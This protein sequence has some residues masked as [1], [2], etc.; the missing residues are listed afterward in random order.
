MHLLAL[1]A[2]CAS[3]PDADTHDTDPAVPTDCTV[4][5]GSGSVAIVWR[6]DVTVLVPAA[7]PA[8]GDEQAIGLAGP[9]ALGRYYLSEPTGV[10]KRSDDGG[11]TWNAVGT[12][13]DGRPE[14]TSDTGWADTGSGPD[15]V[16]YDLFTAPASSRVYA[17]APGSLL[18]SADGVD[19]EELSAISLRAPAKLAIDPTNPDRLRGYD[20]AGLVTSEDAGRTWATSAVPDSEAWYNIAIDAADIDRVALSHRGLWVAT[21][22]VTWAERPHE[23]QAG[24]AWDNG[25]LYA[26]NHGD[27]DDADHHLRR[28]DDLG[29][30]LVDL[31]IETDPAYSMDVLVADGGLAVSAGY[32]YAQGEEVSGLVQLTT[33][34]GS[35]V[36]L[37]PGFDGVRGVAVGSDRVIVAFSGPSVDTPD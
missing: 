29:V 7:G 22:G 12:L 16:Y 10:V 17:Y 15:Y 6:A 37:A 4:V 28:S 35:T 20:A 21:D 36:H 14:G 32:R 34:A 30:T 23:L 33:E 26:L 11:C 13:P 24:L 25:A 3:G 18:G 9:D 2:A 27:D 1:L 19:W 31:P 8:T 5:E